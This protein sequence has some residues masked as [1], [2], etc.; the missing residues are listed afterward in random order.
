MKEF[1]KD[2]RKF[3]SILSS[4]TKGYSFSTPSAGEIGCS[5][6]SKGKTIS[7]VVRVKNSF[8]I[9]LFTKAV[10][11]LRKR[12]T[13]SESPES[14]A[15]LSELLTEDQAEV[16]LAYI[17]PRP[18]NSAEKL[19]Y[20]Y[21]VVTVEKARKGEYTLDGLEVK[22]TQRIADLLGLNVEK[23]FT[24]KTV[25]VQEDKTVVVMRPK[26][27]TPKDEDED[28]DEDFDLD[29]KE[30]K[31]ENKAEKPVVKMK[32]AEDVT[33]ED[34]KE[35]LIAA[36]ESDDDDND[37]VDINEDVTEETPAENAD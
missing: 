18:Y 7:Y 17:Q 15:E 34:A 20:V 19:D 29:Y 27:F 25:S 5:K 22:M 12:K 35:E 10:L 4:L 33:A 11:R 14:P 21:A 37:E 31:A 24:S 13:I 2:E 32:V 30:T 3:R 1:V 6:N 8:S 28:E 9:D 36:T 26:N 16:V 23:L